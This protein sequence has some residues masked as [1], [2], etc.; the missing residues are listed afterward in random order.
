MAEQRI[1]APT[2]R[3]DSDEQWAEWNGN[4]FQCV[5]SD[6]AR[7]LERETIVLRNR[8]AELEAALMVLRSENESA[9]KDAEMLLGMLNCSDDFR[10]MMHA[11]IDARRQYLEATK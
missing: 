11:R 6:F 10:K 7:Q 4:E 3:T 2:P 1:D 5:H 9:D 8:V